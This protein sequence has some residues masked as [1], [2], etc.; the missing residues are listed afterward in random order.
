MCFLAGW[1]VL[2]GADG[3]CEGAF[4]SQTPAPEIDGRWAID[5][6]D[7]LSVEL[8]IGG[9]TY[10]GSLPAEGGELR[11]AAGELGELVFDL[12]CA[13]DEVLCPSEAWPTEVL[14]ER[15]Q[16]EFP[17]R[18]W[19]QIPGQECS[20]FTR[21]PNPEECGEGT[22]NPSCERVCEG[23]VVTVSRDTFGLISEEGDRF[24]LLLGAGVA[25]NGGNCALLGVSS[26]H[27]DLV[28]SGSAESEDWRVDAMRPGTVQ[29]AY[30]GGCL[31]AGDPDMDEELEA[32]VLAAELTFRTGFTGDRIE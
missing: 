24:D 28:T 22:L 25:T 4:F 32:L 12:D 2:L 13:R 23:E 3:G 6:D 19:V 11:V 9:A 17:N 10:E 18:T 15:R 5:Y 29:V 1:P 26:A 7:S 20:G 30:A 14:A 27:A 16:P 8:G 31:W 21:A